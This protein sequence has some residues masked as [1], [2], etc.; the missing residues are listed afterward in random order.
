MLERLEARRE[1]NRLMKNGTI[2]PAYA[3]QPQLMVRNPDAKGG[4]SPGIGIAW[5][6]SDQLRGIENVQVH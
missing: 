2:R 5:D 4:W 6:L 1:R 3:M